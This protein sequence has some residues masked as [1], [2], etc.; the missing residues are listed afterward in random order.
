MAFID[1]KITELAFVGTPQQDDRIALVNLGVT[2]QTSVSKFLQSVVAVTGSFFEDASITDNILTITRADGTTLDLTIASSSYASSSL[3]AS[4]A[5]TASYVLDAVSSSYA[6]SSSYAVTA[7]YLDGDSNLTYR[8]N[9]TGASTYTITHNLNE[10]YP[11]VQTY[12]T[13]TNRMMLPDYVE[14]LNTNQIDIAYAVN[15]TGIVIVQK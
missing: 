14:S 15:F 10:L 7:S 5:S 13:A 6:L 2:K 3:S 12:D 9:V 4:Y 1:K 11:I 8:E